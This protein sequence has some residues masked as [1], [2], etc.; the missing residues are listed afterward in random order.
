[1]DSPQSA[2]RNSPVCVISVP[3]VQRF[4]EGLPPGTSL[5]R[6]FI[7][8]QPPQPDPIGR[9]VIDYFHVWRRCHDEVNALPKVLAVQKSYR[10]LLVRRAQRAIRIVEVKPRHLLRRRAKTSWIGATN[11]F[12]VMK[13]RTYDGAMLNV[14]GMLMLRYAEDPSARVETVQDASHGTGEHELLWRP[15]GLRA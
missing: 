5:P 1:M 6:Y 2:A 14:F 15:P 13:R 9:T 11:L 10:I 7:E 3:M 4:I 8:S 12:S